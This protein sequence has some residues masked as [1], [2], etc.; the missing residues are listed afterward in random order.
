LRSLQAVD[1]QGKEPVPALHASYCCCCCCCCRRQPRR[2]LCCHAEAAQPKPLTH[3]PACAVGGTLLL[4]APWRLCWRGWGVRLMAAATAAAVVRG[5]LPAD[6]RGGTSRQRA[7]CLNRKLEKQQ[8]RL[9]FV[10]TARPNCCVALCGASPCNKAPK[11]S[12][13]RR[14][15]CFAARQMPLVNKYSNGA[16]STRGVLSCPFRSEGLP[17]DNW[18]L[19]GPPSSPSAR[20]TANFTHSTNTVHKKTGNVNTIHNLCTPQTDA[21]H[22]NDNP[23]VF[24]KCTTQANC[25][26][27]NPKPAHA[28]LRP[29]NMPLLVELLMSDAAEQL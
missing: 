21:H 8:R 26:R 25:M 19:P 9:S 17:Q 7:R 4:A 23:K 10:L 11:Q 1:K 14:I 20:H 29:T 24:K 12:L 3:S 2:M 18:M 22:Y 27:H 15:S 13:R 5:S 6:C 16:R 28:L